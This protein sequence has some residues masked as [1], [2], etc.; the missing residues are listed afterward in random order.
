L[1]QYSDSALD[2]PR[3]TSRSKRSNQYG[4]FYY[5]DDDDEED[6]DDDNCDDD[7][8]DYYSL[9]TPKAHAA[10]QAQ[11]MPKELV[12]EWLLEHH[13]ANAALMAPDCNGITPLH[14]AA[15]NSRI[16]AMSRLVARAPDTVNATDKYGR[17]ALHCAAIANC[18]RACMLLIS[19]SAVVSA[20]DAKG[21]SVLHI[22]AKH[23]AIA[24]LEA[25]R[26]AMKPSIWK[27]RLGST[28]KA[29]T[30]PHH[31]A[32]AYNKTECLEWFHKQ[33]DV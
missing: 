17:T 18:N 16:D 22:A 28:T 29:G 25:L 30:L 5:D 32:A 11:A 27:A 24:V 10:E 26:A 21:Q 7:E 8:E 9:S 4:A 2:A 12:L 33:D 13:Q 19:H 6:D 14:L 1:Q 23:G 31:L 20:V 15:S 3:K